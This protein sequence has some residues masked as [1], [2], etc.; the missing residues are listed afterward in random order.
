MNLSAT[1]AKMRAAGMSS[2]A[3]VQA[4]ECIVIEQVTPERSGAARRQAAYRERHDLTST[5]W[6]KLRQFILERDHHTCHYCGAM[7]NAV[8]HKVPLNLGGRS[9]EDNL[10]AACRPCN[11]AKRDRKAEEWK[12]CQ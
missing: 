7:A 8:D 5:E 4:L 10:V 11:S 1:I 12:A 3:I 6:R 2:E 9:N